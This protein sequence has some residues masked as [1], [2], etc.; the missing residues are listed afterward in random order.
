MRARTK[1]ALTN[2]PNS[3][4]KTSKD[5]SQATQSTSWH[6][7]HQTLG[8][9][10]V[11]RLLRAGVI[12][13]KL[14]V[15]Q[16]S[17]LYEKAD[18]VSERDHP[19]PFDVHAR[20]LRSVV[21]DGL[22]LPTRLAAELGAEVGFDLAAVRV[23]TDRRG[24]HVA[25]ALHAEAVTFGTD[26]AVRT[27]CY[28]PDTAAGRALLRHEARH[29]A[30]GAGTSAA[31]QLSTLNIDDVTEEMVGQSFSLRT[32]HGKIPSGAT[33]VVVDWQEV[34]PNA[35]VKFTD[36][37]VTI[38]EEV[39]KLALNPVYTSV[40]GVR[41]Y[42]VGLPGQQKVVEKSAQKVE[43]VRKSLEKL[44]AE[45]SQYKKHHDVW[46][47]ELKDAEA[48]VAN[49]E[50]LLA[51]R[52]EALSRMLVRE[53]MYNRFDADI[54]RWVDFYNKSLKPKTPCDPSIVKSMMFNESRIGVEG[55]HLELPPY[56]WTSGGKHPVRSRFNVMQ[57]IDSSGEQQLLMLK[58][59]APDI[60]KAHKLDEFEKA[61]AKEGLS[62]RLIWGN[63]E[64]GAAVREFFERRTGG[65]NVMGS[66]D[67]DLH[68]DYEFWIR[69]G[70]R[71]LF[72]K[73]FSVGQKSWSEAARAYNG[74]GPG[75]GAK[76]KKQAEDYRN[77]VMGRVGKTT[78]LEV[79]EK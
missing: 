47:K 66:R 8:N 44:K 13:T 61:H 60:Y 31:V 14:R 77:A 64:F 62:E 75:A 36:K 25:R 71:W 20:Q 42:T 11:Q 34:G 67:V 54:V 16:Q 41:Q 74:G 32:A 5:I 33:V 2:A 6:A 19:P 27:D 3:R 46:E 40:K 57:A 22:P 4:S 30:E 39:P 38:T 69:T 78:P 45:E 58:E 50:G 37:G 55:P 26:I 18:E 17:D 70:V 79:G 73:Y 59:I 53:T 9:Q 10:G 7:L 65:K 1:D 15:G 68:L 23:H 12:Q 24:D 51:G 35:Q 29:V 48:E 72:L 63:P 21:G 49:Q 76:A 56:D 52:E 43:S 28:S